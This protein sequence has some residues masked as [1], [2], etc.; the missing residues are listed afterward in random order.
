MTKKFLKLDGEK[1]PKNSFWLRR[2]ADGD[3]E[4]IKQGA[5]KQ[6]SQSSETDGGE[7]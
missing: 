3:V 6:G 1:V 5:E 4:V 7:Q 2:I